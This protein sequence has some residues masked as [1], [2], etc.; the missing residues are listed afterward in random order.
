M[1]GLLHLKNLRVLGLKGVTV[2]YHSE[3]T[4]KLTEQE[5]KDIFPNSTIS[6][7]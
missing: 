7:Y 5:L 2:R 1:R 4:N 6:V 3:E